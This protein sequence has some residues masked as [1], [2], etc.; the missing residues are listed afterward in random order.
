MCKNFLI[1]FLYLSLVF[2]QANSD[3]LLNMN[4]DFDYLKLHLDYNAINKSSFMLDKY[5]PNHFIDYNFFSLNM[6]GTMKEPIYQMV[7]GDVFFDIHKTGKIS[8]LFYKENKSSEYFDTKVAF[9]V[10]MHDDLKFLGFIESKSL[11]ENINQNYSFN[12]LRNTSKGKLGISYLYHYDDAP[13]EYLDDNIPLNCQVQNYYGLYFAGDNINSNCSYNTFDRVNESF[14]L[15]LDYLYENNNVYWEHLSSFQVSNSLKNFISFSDINYDSKY[16]WHQNNI[17]YIV[18][19]NSIIYYQQKSKKTFIDNYTS[20][21]LIDSNEELHT[22]GS[23]HKINNFKL[24]FHYNYSGYSEILSS[25]Y[26]ESFGSKIS[27]EKFN[28]IIRAGSEYDLNSNFYNLEDGIDLVHSYLSKNFIYFEYKN[29]FAKAGLDFGNINVD[30]FND[31]HPFF[32]N[33]ESFEYNYLIFNTNLNWKSL[34]FNFNYSFYDTDYTY[35]N[36]YVELGLSFAPEVKNVRYKPFGILSVNSMVIN[37]IYDLNLTSSNLFEFDLNDF[38]LDDKRVTSLNAQIGLLFDGFRISYE[39][40]NPFNERYNN[41]IQYS[42]NILPQLGSFSKI[43]II[44][45]F[46]D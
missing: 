32:S 8:Q 42:D 5:Y 23:S 14:V 19:D 35:L 27:F 11:K 30:Y 34:K 33:V 26:M 15:G 3:H 1:F 7:P 17:N 29:N 10:D 28:Y 24:D 9:K 13:I 36:Q 22:F 18:S 25:D 31:N 39:M 38:T 20:E 46:K 4:D 41:K 21:D 37:S 44:W 40:M 6:S 45:I 16:S 43:N 2:P 12:V